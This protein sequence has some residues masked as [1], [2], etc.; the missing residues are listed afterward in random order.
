MHLMSSFR[1][2]Q[3]GREVCLFPDANYRGDRFLLGVGGETLKTVI[4]KS[5]S[6]AQGQNSLESF[7]EQAD[8]SHCEKTQNKVP[9][10]Q[11]WL[12]KHAA[13][14]QAQSRE[15]DLLT[16]TRSTPSTK[17][18]AFWSHL[19]LQCSNP[20]R[21]IPGEDITQWKWTYIQSFYKTTGNMYK[22]P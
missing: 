1:S 14:S 5:M 10:S 4:I 2:A 3:L 22:H 12:Q 13:I 18:W 17:T 15:S 11:E 6:T 19:N 9:G 21:L 7:T 20:K 16:C 8:G